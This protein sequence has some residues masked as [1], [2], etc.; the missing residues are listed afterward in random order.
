M[1]NNQYNTASRL[2]PSATVT[3]VSPSVGTSFSDEASRTLAEQVYDPVTKRIGLEVYDAKSCKTS[4]FGQDGVPIVGSATRLVPLDDEGIHKGVIL[5]PS[6]SEPYGSKAE[7]VEEVRNFLRREVQMPSDDAET[8]IVYYI[9]YT[10]LY[11]RVPVAPYLRISG[12]YGS[13]KSR[14]TDA[15]SCLTYR[16]LRADGFSSGAT[17]FR[18]LNLLGG[19]TLN[20]DEFDLRARRESDQDKMDILRGGFLRG[21]PIMRIGEVNGKRV[22]EYFDCFG[23][24]VLNGREAFPD[25]AL[26]SRCFKIVMPSGV[27]IKGTGLKHIAD[28]QRML[29]DALRIRNKLLRFRHEHYFVPLKDVEPPDG[30][31]RLAQLVLPILMTVADDA[32]EQALAAAI[33]GLRGD[34]AEERKN[35]TEGRFVEA[36]LNVWTK[37]GTPAPCKLKLTEIAEEATKLLPLAKDGHEYKPYSAKTTATK[38]R[39]LGVEVDTDNRD[40]DGRWIMFDPAR[41]EALIEQYGL[42]A[43]SLKPEARSLAA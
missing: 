13:G 20:L 18:T 11:D 4:Y 24:K 5:F 2:A 7:L 29:A 31:N 28:E 40:R 19:G 1:T 38:L 42:S 26:E 37:R 14:V 34:M 25:A 6:K 32:S 17:V 15:I 12:D 22:T 9:L 10:W 3:S 41:H 43:P 35:S 36:L 21:R 39:G 27:K 16:T 33:R 8:L 23:P 30:E